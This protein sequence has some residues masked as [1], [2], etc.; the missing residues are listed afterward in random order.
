MRINPDEIHIHDPEWLD[1]LYTRAPKVGLRHGTSAIFTEIDSIQSVRD[2]YEPAAR[3]TG[4]PKSSQCNLSTSKA[5]TDILWLA[6]GTVSHEIHRKRRSA[7]SPLFSKGAIKAS[8][9]MIYEQAELLCI[10]LRNQLDQNGTAEMRTNF[11]AWSTDVISILAFPKPL[12]LLEDLQAAVDYHLTTKASML[13][14]P[15]QK[16]FPWLIETAWKLPQALV[17]VMSP[18]LARSVALYRV[19]PKVFLITLK[20]RGNGALLISIDFRT[21]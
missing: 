18:D 15:L 4:M 3:M 12:H 2:K 9:T 10:S 14:T 11:T 7:I 16:Q 6:F 17:Q 19:R 20:S 13:L 5:S 8:E 1:V 21:C